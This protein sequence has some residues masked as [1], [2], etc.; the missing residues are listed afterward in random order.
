MLWE[1]LLRQLAQPNALLQ[2]SAY[3]VLSWNSMPLLA[4]STWTD[5]HLPLFQWS[6][7]PQQ[8]QEPTCN[9]KRIWNCRAI[10]TSCRLPC[11]QLNEHPSSSQNHYDVSE[12]WSFSM[13][14]WGLNSNVLLIFAASLPSELPGSLVESKEV[15]NGNN[16]DTNKHACCM[17]I[18][19][20]QHGYK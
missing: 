14:Y 16:M 15:A 1:R 10:Q 17:N 6:A 20:F 4:R 2:S 11:Q 3:P 18:C 13:P 7:I 12:R 8:D 19:L 5:I 9:C